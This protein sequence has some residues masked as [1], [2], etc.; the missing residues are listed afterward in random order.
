MF[1]SLINLKF[2]MRIGWKTGIYGLDIKLMLVVSLNI[3][4]FLFWGVDS[5]A[6]FTRCID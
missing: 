5:Q 3:W 1:T 6:F 2:S 4:A